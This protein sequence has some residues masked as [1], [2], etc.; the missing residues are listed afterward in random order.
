MEYTVATQQYL[1]TINSILAAFSSGLAAFLLKRTGLFG[2][3][4]NTKILI[5]G[6]I[7]GLVS[8][9]VLF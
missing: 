7:M 5:N 9:Y 6:S 8:L 1:A 3:Q 2:K 4:W